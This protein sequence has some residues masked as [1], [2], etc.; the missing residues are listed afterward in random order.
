MALPGLAGL[1]LMGR[2]LLSLLTADRLGIIYFIR[3]PVSMSL[4]GNVNLFDM[5]K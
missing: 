1:M 2:W 3:V 5:H 4:K